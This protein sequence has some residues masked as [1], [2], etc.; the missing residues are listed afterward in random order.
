MIWRSQKYFVTL[1]LKQQN[2]LNMSKITLLKKNRKTETLRLTTIDELAKSIIDGQY[3]EQI[4]QL[5]PVYPLM[6]GM[7][8]DDG[9]LMSDS[10]Y[11]R[12]LPRVCFAS[13]MIT[14]QQHRQMTG[15]S[16]LVLLEVN[17][18][19]SRDEAAAIRSGCTQMPQTLLAFIGASCRSVKIVCQGLPV[20]SDTLPVEEQAVRQFHTMLYEKA[21]VAYNAQLGVTIE[22]MEPRLDRVC[23]LSADSQAVYNPVA[24][25]FYIDMSR[26]LSQNALP[27]SDSAKGN[28]DDDSFWNMHHVFEFN[29][30]KAYDSVEGIGP[31]DDDFL[32]LLTS[33]LA[34]QCRQTGLPLGTALRLTLYRL[35]FRSDRQLVNLVFEN[36]YRQEEKEKRKGRKPRV[37]RLKNVPAETLLTHRVR[38]FLE[39]HYDLR[40]N[41]MRGVPEYRLRNGLGFDFQDL[42]PEARNSM[43]L[44]ALEVGITCWDKDIRRYVESDDIAL[45]DPIADYLEHLPRWDGRDRVAELAAC[46]QTDYQ[47]WPHLFNIWMRSMVA[48]W[49][50]KGQLTGNALVP[51]LIGHQGCGK[52][53][54]CRILLPRELREYF[55]DRINF[56]NEAD[57]NLGLTSFALINLDEFDSVTQRQQVVLKY[58]VSTSDLKYRPPYG[59]AYS[60]HRR[61]ASFIGTTNE[62]TPLTDPTG[63]RRFICVQVNGDIDFEIAIDYPQL[64][65]QLCTE[66]K[67]GAPY[68]LS[69]DEEQAL[70]E[71]NRI[72]MRLSGLGEMIL[73]CYRKPKA[74]EAG[75]WL[76]LKEIGERLKQVFGSGI[77]LDASTLIRIGAFMSSP[78]Y[79][80]ERNRK[81]TGMAYRVVER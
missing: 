44:R 12:D 45:Y 20:A 33:A 13:A 78:D 61:Y 36:V 31:D 3:Q 34:D 26:S 74:G 29:L 51:L 23:Y 40:R 75:Q 2:L 76:S 71:H 54:F 53:S 50:G 70:M 4:S 25:P 21:R 43:T 69:K 72:Y 8:D 24:V 30:S 55:N 52:T 5:R 66:I 73:A 80:F 68:W 67:N 9:T 79:R 48:M 57:L 17:N 41:V 7:K 32:H 65:A 81:T 18:L 63:S 47:E 14:R 42:T 1:H 49:Q 62:Q 15:Y 77:R 56:K 6:M 59:K 46:V 60:A 11:L 19:A 35:P 58:L 10:V 28:D 39:S 64:Y 22:K 16:G 27:A 37:D 38:R